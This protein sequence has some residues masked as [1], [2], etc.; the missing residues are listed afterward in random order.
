MKHPKPHRMQF[1][2]AWKRYWKIA[3]GYLVACLAIEHLRVLSHFLRL[4]VY[5][6]VFLF[7][8]V[9]LLEGVW[10]VGAT[11]SVFCVLL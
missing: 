7:L 11:P 10:S 9:V 5:F 8:L 1:L 2:K 6:I 3:K 4:F